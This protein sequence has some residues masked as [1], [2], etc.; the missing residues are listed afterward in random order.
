MIV[1]GVV[2]LVNPKTSFYGIT[3]LVGLL[4]SSGVITLIFGLKTDDVL[5]NAASNTLLSLFQIVIGF[6]FIVKLPLAPETLVV[7]FA[8]WV[9]LEGLSVVV[10]AIDYHRAGFEKWWLMGLL[11][12]VAM[13]LGLYALCKPQNTSIAITSL[14]GMGIVA[15]GFVRLMALPAVNRRQQ[16][17]R[18]LRSDAML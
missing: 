8:L 5:P 9:L 15:I 1:L 18:A 7:V 10:G 14:I 13:G 4:I 3:W 12:M 16:K 6:L 11:G 2:C 17:M